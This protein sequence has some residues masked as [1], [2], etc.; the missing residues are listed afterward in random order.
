MKTG[1][2]NQQA[3]VAKCHN[4][5]IK[6]VVLSGFLPVFANGT[7]FDIKGKLYLITKKPYTHDSCTP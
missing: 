1:L 6:N 5:F 2:P 3:L 7:Y 4:I